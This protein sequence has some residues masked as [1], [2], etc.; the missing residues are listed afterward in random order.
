MGAAFT[1]TV[2]AISHCDGDLAGF[3][4]ATAVCMEIR[5]E[6]VLGRATRGRRA[7]VARWFPAVLQPGLKLRQREDVLL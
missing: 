7:G 4:I 6:C 2:L 1:S 3:S 5:C